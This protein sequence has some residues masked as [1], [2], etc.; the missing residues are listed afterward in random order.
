ML[1]AVAGVTTS[2]PAPS[3]PPPSPPRGPQMAADSGP[4]TQIA[5]RCPSARRDLIY[6]HFLPS[7][8]EE[9]AVLVHVWLSAHI[10]GVPEAT[11]CLCGPLL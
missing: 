2:P 9:V 3:M 5:S 6:R 1:S 10:L 8:K 7:Y 11:T 4:A